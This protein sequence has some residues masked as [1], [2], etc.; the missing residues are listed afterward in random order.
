MKRKTIG[1]ASY[2]FIKNETAYLERIEVIDHETGVRIVDAYQP[3]GEGMNYIRIILT[4]GSILVGLGIISFI[5]SNWQQIGNAL[6][7]SVLASGFLGFAWAGRVLEKEYP[8]TGRSLSYISVL[9]FGA[10]IFLVE[11]M[12]NISIHFS[13]SF[14]LWSLGTLPMAYVLKD[15]LLFLFAH[16]LLLIHSLGNFDYQGIA[17]DFAAVLILLYAINRLAFENR[18]YFMFVE[19]ILAAVWVLDLIYELQGSDLLAAGV[20]FASGIFMKY[21]LSSHGDMFVLE[22]NLF[23]GFSGLALTYKGIWSDMPWE[24]PG[25]A[26][27]I[28]GIALMAYFLADTRK[29]H[30]SS[31]VFVCLLIFRYYV[32]SFYDF[33]P[34]SMFFIIGGLMLIAFGYWFERMRKREGIKN[35]E[36]S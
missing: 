16:G 20:I 30:I 29:G 10:G 27:V 24:F 18:E 25:E 7:L 12:Y 32:D 23:L 35:E 1:S 17:C 36:R 22:G 11:Q 26:A 15:K 31:L 28:F 9:V 6:K 34:K 3:R 21:A 4:I 8:R 5:A 19:N 33:M 2:R 13:K 14:L